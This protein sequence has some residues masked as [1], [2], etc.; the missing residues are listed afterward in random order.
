MDIVNSAPKEAGSSLILTYG[1]FDLFHY[2][3]MRLLQ[4]ARSLGTRLAVG[5]STD[6]FNVIK[7]KRAFMSYEERAELLMACRFVD[8]VFP[9]RCW[10]QKASDIVSHKASILVMG[11][12][13]KGKFDDLG[14][15][16]AISY[17]ERTPLI[18]S[19]LL[20]EGLKSY[21][22][23]EQGEGARLRQA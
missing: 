1:T 6:E 9:E 12:D 4:R 7:G 14:H 21:E 22:P 18:S 10:E 15:L 16:C 5:L 11:D 3:H 23:V 19:T 8:E 13:W 2:G 17:L 20:R